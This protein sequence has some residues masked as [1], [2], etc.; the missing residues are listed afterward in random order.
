MPP[1]YIRSHV[2]NAKKKAVLDPIK[3]IKDHAVLVEKD[4]HLQQRIARTTS[5]F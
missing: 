2:E 5:D 4:D 3:R 1:D